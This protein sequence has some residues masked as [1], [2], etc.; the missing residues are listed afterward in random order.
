V[1]FTPAAACTVAAKKRLRLWAALLRNHRPVALPTPPPRPR[2]GAEV[3][4]HQEQHDGE[5]E[6]GDKPENWISDV[7][8]NQNVDRCCAK[9]GTFEPDGKGGPAPPM[10][11]TP[12]ANGFGVSWRN[13]AARTPRDDLDRGCSAAAGA[14]VIGHALAQGGHSCHIWP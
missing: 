6:D 11:R 7:E 5:H 4:A 10:S 8:H 14:P 12:S 3:A 9:S 2:L 13:T 1:R